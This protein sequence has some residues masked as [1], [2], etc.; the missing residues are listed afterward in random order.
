[1]HLSGK[2][3]QDAPQWRILIENSGVPYLMN[4]AYEGDKTRELCQFFGH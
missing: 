2:D 4:K 3:C 1:M